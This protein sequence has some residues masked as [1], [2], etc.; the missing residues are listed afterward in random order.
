MQLSKKNLFV[1]L[2]RIVP[3]LKNNPILLNITGWLIACTIIAICIG[4]ASAVFLIALHWATDYREANLWLLSLLPLAGIVIGAFFHYWGKDVEAGN[5]LIIDNIHNPKKIIK[6]K[7]APFILI[8]TVLTHLFGGSAGREGTAIQMGGSI[9]DQFTRIFRLSPRNRQI[10]L[11]AGMSAGFGSVFG[12][13]LAGAV[14]GL[15]VYNIGKIKYTA[16]FPAFVASIIADFVTHS[17][18]VTHTQYFIT[19]VP[20]IT[21]INIIYCIIAGVAFG[22]ASI[23]FT[24]TTSAISKFSKAKIKYPPLRLFTGGIIIATAVYLMGTSRYIGLGVPVISESFTTQLPA[25][26]FLLKIAFTALTLGVG[27]K[28]GEVTPLFF[29]GATLGSALSFILP[30]PV[31]LLAGMGFV[32]VFAGSANTPIACT[33]MAIEL[34]GAECGV[35]VAIA[36]IVAYL[37]SGHTGIYSSQIVGEAKHITKSKEIGK[38]LA[39]L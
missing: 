24:K 33:I 38:H 7:M 12:T 2:G 27:F 37:V 22:I 8:G 1:L 15:E 34:F 30:I 20:H 18:G 14:F 35:Y 19:S 23:M 39:D 5:N 32:A 4:S 36:C 17:W 16:I 9:A 3:F 11:I 21:I 31:S 28:G 29:I 6:F 10:L 13:P 25:Y 26:D